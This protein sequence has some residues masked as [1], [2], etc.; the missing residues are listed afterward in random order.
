MLVLPELDL[1]PPP[2]EVH[3]RLVAATHAQRLLRK[4]LKL[5]I[6]AQAEREQ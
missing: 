6:E 2:A 3:R 1:V 5:S 4:L